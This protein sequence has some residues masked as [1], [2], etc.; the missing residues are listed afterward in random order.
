MRVRIVHWLF[1]AVLLLLSAKSSIAVLR[2]H[3]I[4]V[5]H[6]DAILI[7]EDGSGIA[8]IDA[9]KIE[10][11]PAVLAYLQHL[12]IDRLEHLFV[13]HN[14]DD[15]VG[16]I[17]L[18]LDSLKVGIIHHTGM[19]HDWDTAQT[20][21]RYLN[22]KKWQENVVNVGDIPVYTGDVTIEVLSPLKSEAAGQQVDANRYSMVLLL[23]YGDVTILLPA[24]IDKKREKWLI[25]RFG[26][27]LNCRA[28]KAS[29]H[30][31]KQ[32]NSKEFLDAVNPEIVVIC[33][34]PSLWGYPSERTLKRLRQH[35]PTVFRTD[36]DGTVVLETD[37]SDLT[38][39]K[40]TRDKP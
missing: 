38:L 1:I 14:H 26:D 10:A 24:D 20:F 34:G 17:P 29:H 2:V 28:L 22:S 25:E 6:G 5:G 33:V 40:P 15:H 30:A 39:R 27:K 37:G 21:S 11:G 35:C 16:G 7:E 19:V 12:G 31:S 32:S 18:I 13:T 9:G 36:L 4:A 3:F 8:L 23:S